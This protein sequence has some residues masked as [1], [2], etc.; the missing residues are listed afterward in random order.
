MVTM[1]PKVNSVAFDYKSGHY[2]Y[3]FYKLRTVFRYAKAFVVLSALYIVCR[4]LFGMVSEEDLSREVQ[5]RADNGFDAP[6]DSVLRMDE[7]AVTSTH[8]VRLLDKFTESFASKPLDD[9]CVLFFDELYKQDGD[10]GLVDKTADVNKEYALGPYE[11]LEEYIKRRGKEWKEERKEEWKK[12]NKAETPPKNFPGNVPEKMVPQFEQDYL[13][14]KELVLEPEQ[15]MVDSIV[16]VRVF[17]Q[18][19]LRDNSGPS[20]KKLEGLK[21][22]IELDKQ[23]TTVYQDVERRIFPWLSSE[24]PT[25]KRWDGTLVKGMLQISDYIDAYEDKDIVRDPQYKNAFGE[26]VEP[27]SKSH[28]S[29]VGD[30]F[31]LKDWRNSMNGRGIVLSVADKYKT[32]ILGLIRLFRALN[33]KLPIQFVHKGDL[34]AAAQ[35]E[36]I[37]AAR[38]DDIYILPEVYGKVSDQVPQNFPKQEVWFV[39]ASKCINKAYGKSFNSYANKMIALLFN[40][41]DEIMMMDADVLPLIKPNNFFHTGPYERTQT[42][43][44]K[45]RYVQAK[46][47]V[48]VTDFFKKLMPTAIDD[49]LFGIPRAT[50]FTL[51]NRFLGKQSAHLMEA[52]VVLMKRSTHFAGLLMMVRLNMYKAVTEKIWG[53]K[54]L[55]WISQSVAGNE[56]Y[57]FNKYDTASAGALTPQETRPKNSL[58]HELC[59]THPSHVSGDDNH[60][61]LW[62]NSGIKYCKVKNVWE[63]DFNKK[64]CKKKYKSIEDLKEKYSTPIRVSSVIIPPNGD[65]II[66]N[67]IEEPV[68][69]WVA[70]GCCNSYLYCAYDV[71]GGSA[72]PRDQ[73][74]LIQ[75]D[76]ATA[77]R[78]DYFGQLWLSEGTV[79]LSEYSS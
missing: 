2:N 12:Q 3:K 23:V 18:C 56:N 60:T 57:E 42:I 29:T 79:K 71:I 65:R 19:F 43:F 16:Q 44:F 77:D 17:D 53:E 46:K 5:H 9:K 78:F 41:F 73:G 68:K 55:F 11:C 6:E 1:K 58:S 13:E 20:L 33:N 26:R 39:D 10:W 69:G 31:L 45:D 4:H 64:Q 34:S 63:K 24:L 21:N 35:K 36:I 59:S 54:E 52:G 38:S 28:A 62:I 61:L 32:E 40:S 75:Y 50:N 70:T 37:E 49:A 51:E 76:N 48:E 74:I 30:S 8:Y 72:D 14:L 25:F 7:A 66:N 27:A 15:Q 47:Q 67:D 22:N